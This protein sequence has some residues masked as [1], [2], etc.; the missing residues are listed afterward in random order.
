MHGIDSF[1]AR[2]ASRTTWSTE[3]RSTPGID[4]TGMRTLSPPVTNSG[5]IR[6]SVVSTFSRTIRRAHSDLRLRRIRIARSSVALAV[7]A[8]RRGASRSSIGRPN[9]IAIA[10]KL[11]EKTL[12]HDPEN[13]A[14]DEIGGGRR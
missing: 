10:G 4:A 8:L 3:R 5:Q 11:L 12:E 14:L 7:A 2:S 6:S 9:L 13:R 1:A